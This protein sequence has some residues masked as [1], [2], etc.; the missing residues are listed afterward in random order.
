[1]FT[2]YVVYQYITSSK[3]ENFQNPLLVNNDLLTYNKHEKYI[4]HSR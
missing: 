3:E 1:M 2:G 4:K